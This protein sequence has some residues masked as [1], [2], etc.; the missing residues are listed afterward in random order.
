MFYDIL[1]TAQTETIL[2]LVFCGICVIMLFTSIYRRHEMKKEIEEWEH[3]N[4][5]ELY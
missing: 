2:M 3:R 4:G 1:T 5:S